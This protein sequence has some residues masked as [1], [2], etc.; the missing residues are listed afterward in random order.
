MR[1][2]QLG[3]LFM[4]IIFFPAAP[5]FRGACSGHRWPSV[6][7]LSIAALAIAGCSEKAPTKDQI[8][9]RANEAFAAQ[10][11]IQA[12]K[13]Y[14]EI[15][16]RAPDDLGAMRQL[17]TLYYDQGQIAQAYPLLKKYAGLQPDD[18]DMAMVVAA[19][20]LG[21]FHGVAEKRLLMGRLW[22]G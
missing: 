1:L 20:W 18:P 21:S 8:L 10:R 16:R 15:L 6:L 17:G 4:P 13:D 9:S 3:Q 11:Y 14:R 12:E 5:L 22:L 2:K 19:S 7:A